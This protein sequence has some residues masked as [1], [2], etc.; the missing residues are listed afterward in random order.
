M[1]INLSLKYWGRHKKRAFSIIFAITVSMAALTCATLLARSSSVSSLER[2]YLDYSGYYDILFIDISEENFDK[3]LNDDRFSETGV[4]YRSGTITTAGG[5]E[6]VFGALSETGVGLYHFSAEKGRYPQS[7][8][9]ITA[10]RRFFEA[11]GCAAKVGNTLILELCDFDGNI[12]GERELT[13]VGV[14]EDERAGTVDRGYS[15]RPEYISPQV[16]LFEEDIP[17][18]SMRDLLANCELNS[19]LSSIRSEL[20]ENNIDHERGSRIMMLNSVALVVMNGDAS[21]EELY[22]MLGN[23]QKDFYARSLIPIFSAVVLLVAFVSIGNVISTS[24]SERKRQFAML[25]CI[26]MEKRKAIRM[27]LGESLVMVAVGIAVGFPLGT[28]A[29]LLTLYIQNNLMGLIVYPAFTV[30]P[31][32]AATTVN[33][34]IFPAT[35]CFAVSLLAV[36]IPYLI[37]LNKSP[38]EGLRDNSK[39]TSKTGFHARKKAIV[40]GKISGGFKHNISFLIIVA[41]VVW[42][43]VFGYAFFSEQSEIDSQGY[44]RKL[45]RAQLTGLDYI[46]QR[47][48]LYM[49]G[50]AQMTMHSTGIPPH[51]AK[52]ISEHSDVES[53]CAVIEAKSTKAVYNAETVNAD[54]AQA[55]SST[56]IENNIQLGLEE[57]HEKTLRT[58]GYS[59]NEILF[60]VP[61]VGVS[62][63]TLDMLSEFIV[64]GHYDKQK[65]LSGEEILILRTTKKSPYSVGDVIPMTDVVIDDLEIEE[66][67]F[68]HGYMPEGRE[69][70]FYYS[71]TDFNTDEKC[72]GWAFGTRRDYTV[73]I[74]GII[75]ITDERIA[76]FF[77]TDGLIGNSGFNILCADS[78]F[79]G[80]GLPDRNYTKVGVKLSERA[81]VEDFERL[82]FG[83]IGN[84]PKVGSSSV[85]AM[86][87]QLNT[88]GKTN[89]SIFAAIII[90]VV[91]LGLVGMVNSINLRV[92]RGLRSY[93]TLRA[94]GLSK[95]GLVGLI[96]RQGLIYVVISAVTS[97]IPL[98]I[99]EAFRQVALKYDGGMV[100]PDGNGGLDFKWQNLFPTRIEMW[101]QPVLL[102]ICAVMA[103]FCAVILISNTIP[104]MWVARK[105]ITEAIRNDDF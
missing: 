36:L 29:Y 37:E 34:Y 94:I 87:R 22:G 69:P 67:D 18:N 28:G 54:I 49:L 93:S 19:E 47:A 103:A 100:L 51:K 1:K 26:G 35:A 30:H 71:Y 79:E 31:V 53:F 92:R 85:T 65:L 86:K 24:L 88:S 45:E 43:A 42:S 98:G 60:N 9:E 102:I 97:L 105:N 57:L 78:A 48:D 55:L 11:N 84:S 6:F 63:D 17:E 59:E 73:K 15:N 3:Y 62:R 72:P 99:F 56:N 91:I 50:N 21:E 39:K 96:L 104:A 23:A 81:D 83:V 80:W 70:S 2:D 38:V 64:D 10:Y 76:S 44:I 46:A 58:H 13:I 16:F 33:P 95:R 66:F 75:E 77:K 8:G 90:T 89:M 101:T 32:I 41:V 74:G 7:S 68:S 14:L 52:E 5:T 27:A 12:I 40:L 20:R 61:T 25:R 82:W 4:L